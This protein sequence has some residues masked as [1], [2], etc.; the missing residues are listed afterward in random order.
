MSDPAGR[1]TPMSGD[2]DDREQYDIQFAPGLSPEMRADGE[3]IF[4]ALRATR[5]ER[6]QRADETTV[7][8]EPAPMLPMCPVV[9]VSGEP[10]LLP[11]VDG[12]DCEHREPGPAPQVL[13]DLIGELRREVAEAREVA[14]TLGAA[15]RYLRGDNGVEAVLRREQPWWLL[16]G[17]WPPAQPGGWYPGMP[18]RPPR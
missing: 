16:P 14:S 11:L 9:L 3:R 7:P 5:A 1:R 18:P 4:A 15:V 8:G 17:E 10:C 13:A 2:E 12:Q 6:Q